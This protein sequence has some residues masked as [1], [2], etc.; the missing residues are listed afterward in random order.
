MLQIS[1]KDGTKRIVV[2]GCGSL[3]SSIAVS[4]AERGHAVAVLDPNPKS[5]EF[6]PHGMVDG[7][8]IVTIPGD[9]T[10]EDDL[11]RASVGNADVLIAVSGQDARNAL[12]AQMA[13]RMYAVPMV[14]CRIDDPQKREVYAGLGLVVVSATDAVANAVLETVI[15]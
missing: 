1:Q 3:G 4:L 2:V 6:L 8:Q 13:Q 10:R 5:F 7:G 11:A 9:G 12:T 15:K 14:I